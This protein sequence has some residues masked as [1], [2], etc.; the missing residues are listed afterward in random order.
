MM[1]APN[2]F[3]PRYF[4]PRYWGGAQVDG[5]MAASIIGIGLFL[6]TNEQ[7]ASLFGVPQTRRRRRSFL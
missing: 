1:N 7:G 6:I 3:A 5:A 4:A 2:Y